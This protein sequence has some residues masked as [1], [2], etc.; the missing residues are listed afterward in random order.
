MEREGK[1]V[2]HKR[3]VLGWAWLFLPLKQTLKS[4]FA[5]FFLSKQKQQVL[6]RERLNDLTNLLKSIIE[7]RI[8]SFA[9]K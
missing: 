9:S 4:F 5:F 2:R 3:L 8:F 1:E 6:Q 7:H